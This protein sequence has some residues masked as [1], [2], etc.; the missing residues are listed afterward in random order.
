M[1]P[2]RIAAPALARTL[3]LLDSRLEASTEPFD[4]EDLFRP[5]P[6]SRRWAWTHFGV[7]L[8]DLPAP[9]RFLNTMTLIGATGSTCFDDDEIAAADARDTAMLLSATAHA[10]QHHHAGYDADECAFPDGG[11]LR[12]GEHLTLE[13][14]LPRVRV[15]GRYPT[16]EVDLEL[17]TTT[18]ASWFV[19]SAPYDHVS[20]LATVRGTLADVDGRHEV[21]GLGTVEYARSMSP[22]ALLRRPLPSWAKVPIDFFTYQI[23]NLDADTQLLLTDVSAAGTTL[24]RLAH[25]RTRSGAEVYDDVHFEV[26]EWDPEPRYDPS[27]RPMPVPRTM[28]WTVRDCGDELLRL[29]A[30]VDARFRHG[31][32]TG[33]V[34]AYTHRT[35]WRGSELSGTGYLEWVDRRQG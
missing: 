21:A 12:W 16:F 17:T 5:H 31:H 8:P 3:G 22:Q 23:V 33:Y 1:N 35:R 2:L 27:G 34:S 10:D 7:F 11:P 20:L 19:R 28:A 14:D 32:G 30:E 24:C 13:I 29:D 18:A 25:L 26:T 9:Y 15:T 6:R 4:R